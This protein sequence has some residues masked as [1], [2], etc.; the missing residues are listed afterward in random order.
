[1]HLGVF[2]HWERGPLPFPWNA[3]NQAIM[4]NVKGGR[5]KGKRCTGQKQTTWL[6]PLV[7]CGG[8]H[9]TGSPRGGKSQAAPVIL[10]PFERL[11]AGVYAMQIPWVEVHAP[12]RRGNPS[13]VEDGAEQAGHPQP[14][15]PQPRQPPVRGQRPQPGRCQLNKDDNGQDH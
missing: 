3:R 14:Q 9:R 13:A 5:R 7:G 10:H 1:M 6:H 15:S 4:Y 11:G 12:K 8:D 2:A